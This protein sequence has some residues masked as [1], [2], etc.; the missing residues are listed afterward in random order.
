MY[1]SHIL[2]NAVLG[3]IGFILSAYSVYVEHKV[4]HK[5][6]S[7]DGDEFKALCDIES[8]G[9]SCSAVFSLP[10]GK[11]LSFFGLI[12]KGHA[13]DIPNGVLGMLFYFFTIIRFFVKRKTQQSWG[14]IFNVL[15]GNSIFLVISSLA[16]ASSVFLGRKLYIIREFCVVCVST[17]II[18]TTVWIRAIMEKFD[19]RSSKKKNN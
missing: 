8:I 13:L 7:P 5:D 15:F 16:L 14:G 11:M 12:P 18:N 6:D 1:V 3:V 10:E 19:S 17:H 2:N 4:E 9:A